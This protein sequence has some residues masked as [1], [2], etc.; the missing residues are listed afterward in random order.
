MQYAP[1]TQAERAMTEPQR[2]GARFGIDFKGASSHAEAES[3]P[4]V[5]AMVSGHA[6]RVYVF[7]R[8][9]N[10]AVF[11]GTAAEVHESILA[12]DGP[13][14]DETIGEPEAP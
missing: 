8:Q 13:E 6:G 10:K 5:A 4:E 12:S 9:S 14:P 7:D 11:E 3:L 1:A 2:P